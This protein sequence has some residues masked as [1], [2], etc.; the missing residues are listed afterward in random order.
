MT[1]IE[2]YQTGKDLAN[3]LRATLPAS[4]KADVAGE[5]IR[6]SCP[7][8]EKPLRIEKVTVRGWKDKEAAHCPHCG[9]E[10]YSAMCHTLRVYRG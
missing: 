2:R 8:C 10:A 3:A 7:H 5:T 6:V 4:K 9:M 1:E